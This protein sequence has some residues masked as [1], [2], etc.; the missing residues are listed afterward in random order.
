MCGRSHIYTQGTCSQ[1]CCVNAE[2][3][4]KG[5]IALLLF[6]CI[7]VS[8]PLRRNLRDG[9]I[10]QHSA[11]K[12][13]DILLKCLDVVV[14]TEPRSSSADQSLFAGKMF[15]RVKTISCGGTVRIST[16]HA[17]KNSASPMAFDNTMF[18]R[19]FSL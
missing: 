19:G 13:G 17:S 1:L 7:L 11:N 4:R 9:F 3:E 5:T 10:E 16:Q 15:P 6:K 14:D 18:L 2:S 12:N 8:G